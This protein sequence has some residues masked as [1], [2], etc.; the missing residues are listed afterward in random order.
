[1]RICLCWSC[2]SEKN[3]PE[4]FKQKSAQSWWYPER[5]EGKEKG[6]EGGREGAEERDRESEREIVP[7]HWPL[8]HTK[9]TGKFPNACTASQMAIC[10]AKKKTG[11]FPNASTASQMAI[12][13]AAFSRC[14]QKQIRWYHSQMPL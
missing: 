12:C 4:P 5:E 10:D 8:N 3:N 9:K 13:D 11:R 7:V 14:R 1:M 6:R 2:V